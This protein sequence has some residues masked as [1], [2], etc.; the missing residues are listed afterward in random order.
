MEKLSAAV[1]GLGRVGLPLAV[2]LA[3]RGVR[4]K[5]VENDALRRESIAAGILQSNEPFLEDLYLRFKGSIELTDLVTAV[6]STEL[7]FIVVPTPARV[8][9]TLSDESVQLVLGDIAALGKSKPKH[10]HLVVVVSTLMPGTLA[11][12]LADICPAVSSPPVQICYSPVFV[13]L[14]SVLKDL[15]SPPFVLIGT[16]N[17]EAGARLTRF[18]T[19]I[20]YEK[21]LLV[22][23]DAANAEIAKI[24]LNA[25]LAMKIAFAN[26]LGGICNII[27]GARAETVLKIIGRDPR[28]GNSYLR[29]GAPYGG[30]C[31]PRDVDAFITMA[32]GHGAPSILG[33]AI[34]ESNNARYTYL[35]EHILERAPRAGARFGI[36]G[37]AHKPLTDYLDHGFGLSLARDLVQRGYKVIAHEPGVPAAPPHLPSGV[38]YVDDLDQLAKMSDVCVLTYLNWELRERLRAAVPVSV[39]LLDI[40]RLS[41]KQQDHRGSDT[42]ESD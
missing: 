6:Q 24:A 40:W 35:L 30:P 33:R 42:N 34:R 31:L 32:E 12:S 10:P 29:E 20:G 27:N 37:L 26:S 3:S 2:F 7:T 22:E 39:P 25:F 11:G 8:D 38:D 15:E 23:T 28:V 41:E 1:V 9:G 5:G 19:A 17:E 4:V 14:G 18:Y 13:A 36:V 16:N 21:A